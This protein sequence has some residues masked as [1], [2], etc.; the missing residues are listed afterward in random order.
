M[1]PS[2]RESW[3]AEGWL[4][5]TLDEIKLSIEQMMVDEIAPIVRSAVGDESAS[6]PAAIFWQTPFEQIPLSQTQL[7]LGTNRPA[8]ANQSRKR[9]LL[10]VVAERLSSSFP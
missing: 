2:Y 4:M 8:P 6:R 9:S 10:I 3:I 5:V 1:M 7:A